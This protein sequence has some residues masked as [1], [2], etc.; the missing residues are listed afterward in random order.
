MPWNP[1]PQRLEIDYWLPITKVNVTGTLVSAITSY[2]GDGQQSE[3]TEKAS[4]TVVSIVTRPDYSEPCHLDVL[5]GDWAERQAKL[6]LL[7]DGRLTS[8]DTSAQDD[9]GEGLK[10]ALTMAALGAGVGGSFGPAG[11]AIG[12]GAVD[13][14]G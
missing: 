14:A 8:A 3:I 6:G 11:A 9:R 7:P 1:R 2:G 10:A 4:P 5:A 12:F 13:R